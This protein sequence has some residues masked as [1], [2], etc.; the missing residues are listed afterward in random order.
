M[1]N[2]KM[3][4]LAIVAIALIGVIYLFS[5]KAEVQEQENAYM[6]N[7]GPDVFVKEGGFAAAKRYA[8][9]IFTEMYCNECEIVY[10]YSFVENEIDIPHRELRC[11][12]FQSTP[13]ENHVYFYYAIPKVEII[14]DDEGNRTGEWTYR[15]DDQSDQYG[16]EYAILDMRNVIRKSERNYQCNQF[17][18]ITDKAESTLENVLE[19]NYEAIPKDD[20][21]RRMMAY[22][23]IYNIDEQV[24]TTLADYERERITDYLL[25]VQK[26][27]AG[28]YSFSTGVSGNAATSVSANVTDNTE[29]ISEGTGTRTTRPAQTADPEDGSQ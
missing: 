25:S 8:D 3:I 27:N 20:I 28:D 15:A 5:Q 12:I 4:A 14:V 2:R 6:Y 19:T 13:N 21:Q 16:Y 18:M 29:T 9:S 10:Q 17:T 7:Y 11:V 24:A 1:S 26:E 22:G 23:V